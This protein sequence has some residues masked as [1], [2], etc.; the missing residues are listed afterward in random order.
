MCFVVFVFP[1]R[2]RK[3]DSVEL[4]TFRV[5]EGKTWGFFSF[6]KA[7]ATQDPEDPEDLST[8]DTQ[9]SFLTA[10]TATESETLNSSLTRVQARINAVNPKQLASYP[11]AQ[12][13]S[14]RSTVSLRYKIWGLGRLS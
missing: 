4:S 6:T 5:P 12:Q 7:K 1:V 2:I 10:K 8:L 14:K 3:G 13:A 9:L 11:R